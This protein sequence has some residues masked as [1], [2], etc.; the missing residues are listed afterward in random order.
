MLEELNIRPAR[1]D[2]DAEKL[3][4]VAKGRAVSER[5]K[6]D[7]SFTRHGGLSAKEQLASIATVNYLFDSMYNAPGIDLSTLRAKFSSELKFPA[8]T[9][10]NSNTGAAYTFHG[11]ADYV[12]FLVNN[13]VNLDDRD[14]SDLKAALS[15]CAKRLVVVEVK[16]F[17]TV[18][19]PQ[20][21]AE[22]V[23]Q[24]IIPSRR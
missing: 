23:A 5:F 21:I 15:L 4:E 7:L 2:F 3:K 11:A 1:F 16:S 10:A 22:A 18:F 19:K 9:Q 20:H 6:L 24:A 13:S 12:L 17:E 8:G 14:I